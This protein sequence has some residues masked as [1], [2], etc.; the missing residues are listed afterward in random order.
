MVRPEIPFVSRVPSGRGISRLALVLCL[1]AILVL[2][3]LASLIGYQLRYGPMS[4]EDL[5]AKAGFDDDPDV[6]TIE[7]CDDICVA[8]LFWPQNPQDQ[9]PGQRARTYRLTRPADGQLIDDVCRCL[10]H[11]SHAKTRLQCGIT[12][13][14]MIEG[15]DGRQEYILLTPV[16]EYKTVYA[17]W[18]RY[19]SPQLL[20]RLQRIVR[21]ETGV[22][23]RE[24]GVPPK[25]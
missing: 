21:E 9:S 23:E 25:G 18:Y 14:M 2:A 5:L 19:E 3:S 13:V 11:M 8:L 6:R 10:R 12:A 20:R 16:P 7:Y 24:W 22:C 4:G 15:A 1:G 17:D